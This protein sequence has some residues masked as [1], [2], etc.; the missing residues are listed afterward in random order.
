MIPRTFE[1]KAPTEVVVLTFDYTKD[2]RAGEALTGTPTTYIS[3][4]KG[5]DVGFA[6]V[7]SGAPQVDATGKRC[8]SRCK[9][10]C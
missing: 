10:A 5:E 4:H 3:V 8:C 9:A 1:P 2:L 7:V 6:A